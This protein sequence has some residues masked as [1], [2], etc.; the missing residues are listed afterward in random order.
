MSAKIMLRDE[1]AFRAEIV[2]HEV[3]IA[4]L[5]AALQQLDPIDWR[6]DWE[7]WFALLRACK[8]VGIEREDFVNWCLG[9]LEYAADRKRIERVWKSA[10]GDHG[11]VLFEA[12]ADRGIARV[13]EKIKEQKE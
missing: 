2:G 7:G 6:D 8:A 10:R 11:G 5:T 4:N 9:D 13:A 1:A 12:L 3:Q